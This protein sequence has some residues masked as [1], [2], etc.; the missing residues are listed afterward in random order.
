MGDNLIK[1]LDRAVVDAS[2]DI[3]PYVG[4]LWD[5]YGLEICINSLVFLAAKGIMFSDELTSYE[6]SDLL[7]EAQRQLSLYARLLKAHNPNSSDMNN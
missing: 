6:K 4:N 7:K 2:I 3:E 1:L 5:K